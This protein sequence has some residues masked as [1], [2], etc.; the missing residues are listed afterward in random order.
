[1]T[2]ATAGPPWAPGLTGAGTAAPPVGGAI[3]SVSAEDATSLTI[4][5]A[6]VR[7]L[8]VPGDHLPQLVHSVVLPGQNRMEDARCWQQPSD[9]GPGTGGRWPLGPGGGFEVPAHRD[10]SVAVAVGGPGQLW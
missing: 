7:L 9:G 3:C 4:R 5:L 2:D 6:W 1:V 8:P 10:V